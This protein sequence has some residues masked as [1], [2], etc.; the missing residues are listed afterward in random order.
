MQ[1]WKS[2]FLQEQVWLCINNEAYDDKYGF[3]VDFDGYVQTLDHFIRENGDG[4]K[5]YIGATLDYHY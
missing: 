5:Y 4:G 3:Y 1:V 2:S